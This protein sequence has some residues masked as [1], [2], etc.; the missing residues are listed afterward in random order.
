VFTNASLHVLFYLEYPF[1]CNWSFALRLIYYFPC[2]VFEDGVNL[3]LDSIFPIYLFISSVEVNGSSMSL[4]TNVQK[5]LN[6][7]KG[8]LFLLGII[9]L[10]IQL[11]CQ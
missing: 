1:A 11:P 7:T 4:K 2:L 5:S 10:L 8:F 3:A 6:L 9:F